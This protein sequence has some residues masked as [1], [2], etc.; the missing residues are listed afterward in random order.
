MTFRNDDDARAQHVDALKGELSDKEAALAEK[1]AEIARLRARLEADEDFFG[2]D[3]AVMATAAKNAPAPK[4]ADVPSGDV[5]AVAAHDPNGWMYGLGW[6]VVFGAAAAYAWWAGMISAKEL[7]PLVLFGVP[8]LLFFAR[9]DLV[10]DRTRGTVT[11]IRSLFLVRWKRTEPVGGRP[12]VMDRRHVSP[13]DGPS[14]WT[15]H[16]FLG[17]LKLFVKREEA[18]EELA[19]RIA[20]FLGVEY[21]RRQGSAASMERRALLPLF[22]ALGGALVFVALYLLWA[23]P[24]TGS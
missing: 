15:G 2:E 10:L 3:A 24:F 17:E 13:K 9:N 8:G 16:V 11:R 5:W 19:K 20:S 21:V 1:D 23:R 18:A 6:I 7:A 14:Y 12:I 4:V 22:L